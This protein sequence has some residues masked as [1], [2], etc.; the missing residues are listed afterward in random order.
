MDQVCGN[1][2]QTT[3]SSHHSSFCGSMIRDSRSPSS[4]STR[5]GD[6]C[7]LLNIRAAFFT[8]GY[9]Y[10]EN[11]WVIHRVLRTVKARE[12]AASVGDPNVSNMLSKLLILSFAP[13]GKWGT[14]VSQGTSHEQNCWENTV[15]WKG[16]WPG[17]HSEIHKSYVMAIA[18]AVDG[19]RR[20]P[21]MSV[22]PSM[23]I[24]P[25]IALRHCLRL[26]AEEIGVNPT[27]T[28]MRNSWARPEG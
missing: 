24:L 9:L 1:S 10:F 7:K 16:S 22:L 4:L 3:S 2:S 18:S 14:K 5:R 21:S 17:P 26:T 13:N 12:Y 11:N 8:V 23:V 6:C 25:L 27:T 28:A 15:H 20:L 19:S